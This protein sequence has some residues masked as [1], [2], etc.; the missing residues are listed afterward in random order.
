MGCNVSWPDCSLNIH[1]DFALFYFD[2]IVNSRLRSLGPLPTVAAQK[3]P[4]CLTHEA[5]LLSRDHRERL[6]QPIHRTTIGFPPAPLLRCPASSN[7]K[8][9]SVSSLD[10]GGRPVWKNCTIS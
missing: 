5:L 6:S 2:S 3:K 10:T 9:S 4:L 8:I 7:A 1:P